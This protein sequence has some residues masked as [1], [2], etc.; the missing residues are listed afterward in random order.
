MKRPAQCSHLN[1]TSSPAA[2]LGTSVTFRSVVPPVCTN[3]KSP[4]GVDERPYQTR[5]THTHY[6][7]DAT[8]VQACADCCAGLPALLFKGGSPLPS[9]QTKGC[10]APGK[11]SNRCSR[12]PDQK[13]IS[14]YLATL[15]K[16]F[17]TK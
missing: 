9:T 3:E 1:E 2:F 14:S 11:Y 8:F 10:A 13:I 4:F 5:Q 6:G 7:K 17:K 16:P 15:P 12:T